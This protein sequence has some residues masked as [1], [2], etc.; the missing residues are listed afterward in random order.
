MMRMRRSFPRSNGAL[1][2]ALCALAS[3][4]I[5]ACVGPSP[6]QTTA[7]AETRA[8]AEAAIASPDF[9][10]AERG[11]SL[12]WADEFD[13]GGLDRSKWAPEVSCWGGGNEER[14][15]Y[16]DR[17]AN[18]RVANG[19]LRIVAQQES[20]TGP[21]LPPE[22]RTDEAE[23]GTQ[24]FTSGKIRTRGLADWRYGRFS[25]RMRLPSGQGTWP[26]FWM[27]PSEDHY[28]D[29]PLSG[30]IDIMEAVNLGV[31]C[32]DCGSGRRENRIQGAL[33]FG[34]QW[35][36]NTFRVQ[37]TT[38]PDAA[39]PEDG[40]HVY[41]VEW[42]AGRIDWYVDGRRFFSLTDDDWYTLAP[43]GADNALA[44]FDRPFYLILNLA[45]GGRLSEQNNEGG[46]D[47]GA[48]PAELLVDWVRVYGCEPDPGQG[49][50]C[51]ASE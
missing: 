11:W 13:G 10:P 37:R 21:N 26:A 34:A 31:R 48:F 3:L 7:V 18:I 1:S 41:A 33:H 40:F 5:A 23:V 12:I 45:V 47:R 30:E 25:A 35:P 38:L 17:D 22:Q 44:P 51:M 19:V 39:R 32:R 9:L 8:Q 29:W 49:L 36:E 42:G 50:G 46:V 28:G 15:C 2:I 27:M 6:G 4:F 14:Q 20:W 16:T 43:G 24:A